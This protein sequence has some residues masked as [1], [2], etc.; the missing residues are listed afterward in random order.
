[1]A[2]DVDG[3]AVL[4]TGGGTGIGA[5]ITARLARDGAWVTICGRTGSSLRDT[6]EAVNAEVGRDAVRWQVADVTVP[7]DVARVVADAAAWQ[8]RLD[9]VVANAGGGAPLA[10]LHLQDVANFERVLRLNVIGTLLLAQSAVPVFARAGGGSFVAISSVAGN[11]THPF[12]GAY[13][14][15]KAA[16]EELVR[17]AADEYGAANIRF[18]A[19]RPG[20]TLTES[21]AFLAP[22]SPT[23]RSYDDNTPLGG[24]QD[25]DAVARVVAFLL[26]PGASRMTGQI[27]DVDG[28][29]HLRRGPDYWPMVEP[30]VGSRDVALGRSDPPARD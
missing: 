25:V 1:M 18:N 8:G 2:G 4:V 19:V 17:N 9:G 16:V 28:G 12:F 26:S 14:V 6:A 30:R 3:P 11:L 20:L 15:A 23:Y 29:Q 7:E 21:M 10:P 27:V 5:G 24:P 13:P 22:G